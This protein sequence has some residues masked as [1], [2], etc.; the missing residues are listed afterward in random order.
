MKF[1]QIIHL[2]F[3]AMNLIEV[4]YEKLNTIS[5][6]EEAVLVEEPRIQEYGDGGGDACVANS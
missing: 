1:D 4:E 6:I 5:S 2:A 3:E